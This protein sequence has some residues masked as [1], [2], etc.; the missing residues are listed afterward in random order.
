[1]GSIGIETAVK[2]DPELRTITAWLRQEAPT[3]YDLDWERLRRLALA[4]GVAPLL[5][6]AW[7]ALP[8]VAPAAL[9]EE[10]RRIRQQAALRGALGLR[11]RD[12]LVQILGQAGI[13]CLVLKGAAL[14]RTWYGELSLRPFVDVDLLLPAGAVEPARGVLMSAGYLDTEERRHDHHDVPLYRPG[15]VCGVELHHTLVALPLRSPLT[16]ETLNARAMILPGEGSEMR[17]LGPEDTV[18]HLCLHLL[19]H[20]Q[21]TQ[22]WRLSYLWDIARHLEACPID[23]AVFAAQAQA[24]GAYRGCRAVL[25]LVSLVTAASI[26][27]GEVDET[28]GRELFCYAVPDQLDVSHHFLAASLA[29]LART[30][31]REF[32]M[33]L[34]RAMIDA[35]SEGRHWG[36]RDLRPQLLLE[37]VGGLLRESI[38]DPRRLRRQLEIWLPEGNKLT[39]RERF[40]AG[41]FASPE[42]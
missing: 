41:L 42:G 40:I 18:L 13:P 16:F 22:G 27:P 15:M 6:R 10:F 30:D 3:E 35:N 39:E 32:G 38:S 26:C 17:T 29:A 2:E 21:L 34:I 14:G 20:L 1:M 5:D 19:H 7:G 9:V 24:V 25:G 31:L 33:L 28:A 4:H 11:Q 8:G 36:L 12:E 37:S 23:W